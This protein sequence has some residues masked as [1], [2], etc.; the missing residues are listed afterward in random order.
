MSPDD[1]YAMGGV[2][3][4]PEEVQVAR[5]Q[6]QNAE[7]QATVGQMAYEST[8]LQ[9]Q[10]VA[11][12]QRLRDQGKEMSEIHTRNVRLEEQ[13]LK[14]P[15]AA[16]LDKAID[17]YNDL[18]WGRY[19]RKVLTDGEPY[20]KNMCAELRDKL[21]A[22]E[23]ETPPCDPKWMAKKIRGQRKEIRRLEKDLATTRQQF[24]ARNDEL[25]RENHELAI[26]LRATTPTKCP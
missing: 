10:V 23:A 5:L 14:D 8:S 20:Y 7:L 11:L 26:R 9:N 2:E 3:L 18:A 12:T 1:P 15:T 25:Y 21:A 19:A 17:R 16:A 4:T 22:M 24:R 13:V 6:K